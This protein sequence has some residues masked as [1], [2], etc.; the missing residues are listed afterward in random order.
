MTEQKKKITLAELI[1]N[2]EKFDRKSKGKKRQEFYL[3]ELDGTVVIEEADAALVAESRELAEDENYEGNGDDF[4]VYNVMV[5]PNLKD[6]DLQK[7][8]EC[9]EP[10]DIVTK[11]FG[12]G[13]IY[14]LSVAAMELGGFNHKVTPVD[15]LKN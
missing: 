1:K 2:K 7:A 15:K 10:V 9:V 5:E 11:I 6:P 4:L 3:E 12:P 13:T 14:S 8:Y